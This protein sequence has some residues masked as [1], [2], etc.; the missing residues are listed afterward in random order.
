LEDTSGDSFQMSNNNGKW[1]VRNN[2]DSR[3]DL[4]ITG[5]G[6]VGIGTSSPAAKLHISSTDPIIR[7]T[8]S[9]GTLDNKNYEMRVVG[10]AGYEGFHI[11]SVNDANNVYNTRLAIDSSGRLLIGT[12]TLPN[13]AQA[14]AA[15]LQIASGTGGLFFRKYDTT[16]NYP[17]T[18]RTT[19]GTQVGNVAVTE[20]TTA[21][22][23]SSDYRLKTNVLPMTGAT[24]TF[25]QL[26]PV[27]FEWIKSGERVDGFLAHELQEVIPAAATGSKDAMMDEEYEVTPAVYEDVITPS[28]DAVEAT[29]DADDVELT[30][31]VEA[32]AESTE[33]VLVTEAVMA[34]RSVPDMQGIDQSKVVPL[35][36]ATLQE[37]LAE[38]ET[39]K[40]RL[41]ALE[42]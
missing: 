38:I 13:N 27:N 31:A 9:N 35:L 4:T 29:F 7:M 2:T 33:S 19:S 28:V 21:Y 22:N 40:T 23:T 11:R 18:F 26:K 6:K 12:S 15:T 41:T 5:G 24:A 17:M 39:L 10:A 20:T 3:D 14:Y 16:T 30:P 32:V 8:D 37:A 34:T 36:V 42:V 25:M 1:R